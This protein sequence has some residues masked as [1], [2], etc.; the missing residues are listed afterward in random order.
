MTKVRYLLACIILSAAVLAIGA[1]AQLCAAENVPTLP[2]IIEDP[3]QIKGNDQG[4]QAKPQDDEGDAPS[5]EPIPG[6]PKIDR[7]P[8]P[9]AS[10]EEDDSSQ[11]A[12]NA[13]LDPELRHKMLDELYLQLGKAKDAKLAEPIAE[14][15]EHLWQITGSATIDLLIDRAKVFGDG[16]D[17]DLSIEILDA[18]ADL[19]PDTAEV[20]YQRGRIYA[21]RQ[22]YERAATDLHKALALDPK[23]YEAWTKLGDVLKAE[24][25]QSG[26]DEAYGKAKA[27]N[28]FLSD[29]QK[30]PVEPPKDDNGQDI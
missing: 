26:A 19:A 8:P 18:A 15:I 10:D 17:Q 4:E 28:P 30:K 23:H 12:T 1:R 16:A 24:G 25:D 7:G 5:T 14:S 9:S 21:M 27:I 13:P 11:F 20:W 3:D 22:D 29:L 6:D 2:R